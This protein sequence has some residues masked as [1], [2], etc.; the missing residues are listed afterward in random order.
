[1]IVSSYVRVQAGSDASR[2]C[3]ELLRTGRT[4]IPWTRDVASL[5]LDHFCRRQLDGD[6]YVTFAWREAVLVE[7][8]LLD[9]QTCPTGALPFSAGIPELANAVSK[10]SELG[11]QLDARV[12]RLERAERSDLALR[13]AAVEC[14]EA[15]ARLGEALREAYEVAR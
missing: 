6:P 2:M 8:L 10:L 13:L 1:M 9:T 5:G 4:W 11:N 14:R 15:F 12:T 7:N 3:D